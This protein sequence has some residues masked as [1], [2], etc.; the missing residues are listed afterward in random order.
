[1]KV[2][3]FGLSVGKDVQWYSRP[4]IIE[5][6]KLNVPDRRVILNCFTLNTI[7]HTAV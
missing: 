4:S 7:E 6:F 1:M 3:N 2:A 5:M